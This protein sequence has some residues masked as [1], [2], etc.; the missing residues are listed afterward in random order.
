MSNMLRKFRKHKSCLKENFKDAIL[1]HRGM[2]YQCEKCG[3]RWNMYLQVGLEDNDD[4]YPHKPVP[5]S[6]GCKCGG[7]ANHVDWHLDVK[8]GEPIPLQENMS[9]FK[10]SPD[11]DCGIPVL[12]R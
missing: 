2:I 11:S 12:R 1:I 9:Y 8:L 7:W 6:I 5:F 10:N 4:L 3:K